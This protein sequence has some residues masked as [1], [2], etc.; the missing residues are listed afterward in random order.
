MKKKFHLLVPIAA[1]I[2][3]LLLQYLTRLWDPVFSLAISYGSLMAVLQIA[4]LRS[5]AA[6]CV[7]TA[8]MSAV[9]GLMQPVLTYPTI[10]SHLCFLVLFSLLVKTEGPGFSLLAASLSGA[11]MMCFMTTFVIGTW[12][13]PHHV[14][15]A[16]VNHSKMVRILQ[17]LPPR[18]LIPAALLGGGLSLA[19]TKIVRSKF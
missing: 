8:W 13:E 11:L 16:V 10:F 5:A 2:L 4:G 3:T 1:V 19:V 17:A 15:T 6:A 12:L 18:R 7:L 14:S 9:F